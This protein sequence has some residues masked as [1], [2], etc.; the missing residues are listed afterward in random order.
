MFLDNP[1]D[2]LKVYSTRSAAIRGCFI[3]TAPTRSHILDCNP[4]GR[5]TPTT[6]TKSQLLNMIVVHALI[7]LFFFFSSAHS[8]RT[9]PNN[10]VFAPLFPRDSTLFKSAVCRGL[11]LSKA[12]QLPASSAAQFLNPI[13][14]PI[15]GNMFR[16]Y[17]F[18]WGYSETDEESNLCDF[19][20]HHHL[21]TAFTALG[22]DPRSKT[23]GGPNECHHT[24]HRVSYASD[25]PDDKKTPIRDQVYWADDKKYRVSSLP[26]TH[27][28]SL[29]KQ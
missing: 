29:R 24:K 7:A 19:D 1:T 14:S 15:D 28:C 8:L 4:S 17:L 18:H 2:D 27:S 12:M 20:E 22:W 6:S 26:L 9:Y 21:E 5:N 13:D 3:F 25:V 23:R 11:R 10:T 16:D